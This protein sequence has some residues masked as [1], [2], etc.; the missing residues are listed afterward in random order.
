MPN[1]QNTY[2]RLAANFTNPKHLGIKN[3]IQYYH[4]FVCGCDLCWSTRWLLYL[5][6]QWFNKCITNSVS[7]FYFF[8]DKN[9]WVFRRLSSNGKW[10]W[11]KSFQMIFQFF[12]LSTRS[13][14]TVQIQH[15]AS[16]GKLLKFSSLLFSLGLRS[17]NGLKLHV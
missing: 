8:G 15:A 4:S 14:R 3:E 7:I 13:N 9:W 17:Q 12:F 11:R 5:R 10:K 6:L 1:I 16:T 2:L